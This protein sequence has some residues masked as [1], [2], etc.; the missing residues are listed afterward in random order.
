MPAWLPPVL[1]AGAFMGA[2]VTAVMTWLGWGAQRELANVQITSARELERIKAEV[3]TMSRL[4]STSEEKRAQVAAEAL[5]A[6][7]RFLDALR[8]LVNPFYGKHDPAPRE[9]PDA[10]AAFFNSRWDR[11]DHFDKEF[12]SAWTQAEVYLPE[13]VAEALEKVWKLRGN[14]R[15]AQSVASTPR[16]AGPADQIAAYYLEGYG[17]DPERRIEDLRAEMK[18]LLRPL[19]RPDHAK[20]GG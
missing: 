13:N 5:V 18:V 1:S 4:H 19:A 6:S 11:F 15:G 8:G 20:P 17:T 14:V 2:I 12:R 9:D 3:G 7:L 16:G 10:G